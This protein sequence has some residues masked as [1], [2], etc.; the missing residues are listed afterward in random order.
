MTTTTPPTSSSSSNLAK[1]TPPRL[2]QVLQREALFTRLDSACERPLVWISAP[3]GAGKTT[4][5]GSYLKQRKLRSLWYQVDEG[6]ADPASFF[7]FLGLAVHKAAP[8]G[9]EP[10]PLLTPEYM[11]DLETFARNYFRE[12][13]RHLAPAT[14]LVFDN[15]QL[16]AE[17]SPLHGLLAR[18]VEEVPAGYSLV[19]LSRN[20]PPP[21][22]ARWRASDR[23]TLLDWAALKLQPEE[24]R[25]I[26]R[27][28]YDAAALPDS[29]VAK[30]HDLSDGW[31]AGLTLLLEQPVLDGG[32]AIKPNQDALFDYFAAEIFA[33][34]TPVWQTFLLKTALLPIMAV[35]AAAELAAEPQAGAILKELSKRN[36]FTLDLSADSSLYQYHALFRDFLLNKGR[37]RYSS[38]EWQALQTKAAGLL[39]ADGFISEAANLIMATGDMQGLAGLILDSAPGMIE[40]GRFQRL[41]QW[42]ANIPHTLYEQMPWLFY[43]RG[44]CYMAADFGEAQRQFERAFHAF[45]CSNDR[46]GVMLAW[47]GVVEALMHQLSDLR[48]LDA[49]LDTLDELVT[50]AAGNIPEQLE[51]YMASRIYMAMVL[52][53]PDHARLSYWKDKAQAAFDTETVSARNMMPGFYLFTCYL[54]TD[55]RHMA[56]RVIDSMGLI[57]SNHYAP[58]VARIMA[59]LTQCWYRWHVADFQTSSKILT[60]AFAIGRDTGVHLWDFMLGVQG[61]IIACASG[62]LEHAAR[63]IEGLKSALGRVRKMDQ[64]YF[65][66]CQAWYHFLKGELREAEIQQRLALQLMSETGA[67]Y[68]LA[69]ITMGMCKICHAKGDIPGRDTHLKTLQDLASRLRSPLLNYVISMIEA[70]FVL[71]G[72]RQ[73]DLRERLAKAFRL[74]SEQGYLTFQWW[75]PEETARLCNAALEL[76]VETGYAKDLITR[77]K[78]FPAENTYSEHWP[79]PVRIHTLGRFSLYLGEEEFHATGSGQK[80]P[81]ELLKALLAFGGR[82]VSEDKLSEALWPDAEGDAAHQNLATTLH[83][84]RKLLGQ[85]GLIV[86]QGLQLSLDRRRCRVDIW[87][88]ED[89]LSALERGM[90]QQAPVDTLI[91]QARRVLAWYRGPF[92]ASEAEESWVLSCR[93]RLRS[94]LLRVL[95]Q[96]GACVGTHSECEFA[97]EIYRKMLEVEPL[98]EGVYRQLMACQAV[99][100]QMAEALATYQRCEEVLGRE[101]GITP[102]DDTMDLYHAI[103]QGAPEN[104]AGLCSRIIRPG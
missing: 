31:A 95:Q 80:K 15:Y 13:F 69:E 99:Q 30:L 42:L 32:I 5:L 37:E 89:T 52:R 57:E 83:R 54:W 94:R 33:R 3:G 100:G 70:L 26:C 27:A 44:N 49:W 101:L 82:K 38:A 103:R 7:Y 75:R 55:Q 17:D 59:Q 14:L 78:L 74:G 47:T 10:L 61:M 73:E 87:A 92:L 81:L 67:L 41:A 50:E 20:T 35:E 77:L 84:L 9:H 85:D 93:E 58:P 96:A 4:L 104:V 39:K 46:Q 11:E 2:F 97:I 63:Q 86:K 22:F 53:Q 24:S 28:R 48:Q 62:D 71:E 102:N 88:L 90:H 23:L 40:T 1:I 60:S 29:L 43:W 25:A 51:S 12:L 34:A 64:G 79:W 72:S 91:R 45:R 16:L 56:K 19:F 8:P 6:D 68:P 65:Y 36:Y 66:N 21:D 98:A 76:G 18:L